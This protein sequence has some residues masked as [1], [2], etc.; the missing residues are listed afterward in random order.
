MTHGSHARTDPA[1]P[2]NFMTLF[3]MERVSCDR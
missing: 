3:L 2:L 1:E